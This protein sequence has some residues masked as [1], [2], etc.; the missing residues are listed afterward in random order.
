MSY[1]SSLG[2]LYN[3]HGYTVSSYARI[4]NQNCHL[5]TSDNF[6][7]KAEITKLK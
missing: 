2:K 3:L 7:V 1:M 5:T 6:S 4:S